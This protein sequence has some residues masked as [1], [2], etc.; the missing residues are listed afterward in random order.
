MAKRIPLAEKCPELVQEWHPIKNGKK[1]P[2][3]VSYGSGYMAWWILEH[4][5][6][7]SGKVF[8]FEWQAT[9]YH[10]SEGEGCPYLTGKRVYPGFN[11]LASICPELIDQVHP[12]KND[13]LTATNI[14]AFSNKKIW[15]LYP[16]DDPITGNHFDFEWEATVASRVRGNGCPYISNQS[17]WK[18]FNDFKTRFPRLA[19]EWNYKRNKKRPEDYMPNSRE[20]V[21]WLY[22]YDDPDTGKH[23]D[24]EWEA[25]ITNR[26]QDDSGCPFLSNNAVFKGFNDLATKRPDLADE[27]DCDKNRIRPDEVTLFSN[28]KRW[29]ICPICGNKWY[30]APAKRASGQEC[31]CRTGFS[32]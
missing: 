29:W 1:T 5:E 26:V 3:N 31:S 2:Y 15:W 8:V 19:L 6:D 27:W 7:R 28:K 32:P 22:P 24:F 9:V 18:G 30:A 13:G 21:W 14:F 12:I 11:D 4:K 23:Y 16:Y 25:R 20:K 10:R 17:L